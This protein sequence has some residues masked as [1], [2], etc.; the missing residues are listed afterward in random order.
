MTLST[1]LSAPTRRLYLSSKAFSVPLVSRSI[2]QNE[3]NT[4]FYHA[5]DRKL[6]W[7]T[8]LFSL[9]GALEVPLERSLRYLT[10]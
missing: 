7:E 8:S 1:P 2:D 10:D 3:I 6:Y 5:L 9:R 4:N